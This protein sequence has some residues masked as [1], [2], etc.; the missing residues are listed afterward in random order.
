VEF[1]IQKCQTEFPGLLKEPL[2]SEFGNKEDKSS[3]KSKTSPIMLAF[4]LHCQQFIEFVRLDRQADALNYAQTILSK[5]GLID[6][7]YLNVLR[8]NC[9]ISILKL[10]DRMLSH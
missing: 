10:F 6:S 2:E 5:F 8:V 1:A 4:E 7:N 9:D 3:F